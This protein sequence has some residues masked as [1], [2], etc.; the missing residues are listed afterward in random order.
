MH[1]ILQGDSELVLQVFIFD[2]VTDGLHHDGLV[3]PEGTE[4]VLV[5]GQT[6]LEETVFLCSQVQDGF[7]T[8][9]LVGWIALDLE[10]ETQGCLLDVVV[11]RCVIDEGFDS[12]IG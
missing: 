3:D 10:S 1:D 12:L 8:L 7:I 5:V 2:Q 4:L 9:T 6:Q 11:R